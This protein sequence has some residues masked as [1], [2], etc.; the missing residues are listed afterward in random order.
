MTVPVTAL[1]MVIAL[2]ENVI[3]FWDLRVLTVGKVSQIIMDIFL[4]IFLICQIAYGCPER[5]QNN[6][7]SH[8]VLPYILPNN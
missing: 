7:V 1:G 6:T 8:F 5:W 2:L 3:A 4:L